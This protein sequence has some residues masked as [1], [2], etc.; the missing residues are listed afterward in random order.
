MSVPS[1]ALRI[2]FRRCRG[3]PDIES[4]DYAA[5]SVL[6]RISSPFPVFWGL[7]ETRHHLLGHDKPDP[8]TVGIH[9]G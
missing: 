9:G 3:A 1:M 6:Q 8:T 2:K 5:D 4:P 7:Q